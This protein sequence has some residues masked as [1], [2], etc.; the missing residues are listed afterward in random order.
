VR[1]AI[2]VV[3]AAGPVQWLRH[4]PTPG[5]GPVVRFP[6]RAHA[7]AMLQLV[8]PGLEPG[9]VAQIVPAPFAYG[10]DEGAGS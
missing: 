2:R 10:A 6:T 9:D 3:S 5:E 4:G 1:Y 8:E 7:R